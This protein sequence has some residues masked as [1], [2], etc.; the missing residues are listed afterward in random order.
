MKYKWSEALIG[1]GCLGISCLR[2][3]GCLGISLMIIG[4]IAHWL[5]WINPHETY[6]WY[7]GIW[8]G[9]WFFPNLI[10]SFFTNTLFK[11][12]HYTTSYNLFWWAT[13]VLQCSGILLGSRR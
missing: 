3:L 2:T 9:L 13:V 4:I 6:T 1:A 7:S 12:E 5:C 8:H 10:L 11:A